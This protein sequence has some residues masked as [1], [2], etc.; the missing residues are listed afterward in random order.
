M[1]PKV[2][3]ESQVKNQSIYCISQTGSISELDTQ[4]NIA[5][6]FGYSVPKNI[7]NELKSVRK[8]LFGLNLQLKGF[9]KVISHYPYYAVHCSPLTVH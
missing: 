2:I 1:L 5:Q 7:E 6:R 4:V 8:M 3:G 9:K